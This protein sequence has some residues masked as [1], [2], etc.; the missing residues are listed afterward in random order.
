MQQIHEFFHQRKPDTGRTVRICFSESLEAAEQVIDF[1][2]IHPL[3]LITYG[4]KQA[5][6]LHTYRHGN[7][8]TIRRIFKRI[9]Q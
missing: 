6:G 7:G 3:A 1:P 9:G 8:L 5:T 4:N 2:E